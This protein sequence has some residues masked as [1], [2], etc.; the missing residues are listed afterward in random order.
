MERIHLPYA[1][2]ELPRGVILD[3][4][5]PPLVMG[6]VNCNTDSFFPPS[7]ALADKAVER[8]LV[9]V[10]EGAEII[11][12]GAESTRP[13]AAYISSGE[14]LERLI[15]VIEAIRRRSSVPLS[16][17]TR[18]AAVAEACHDAG[19][20]MINDISALEDD[21]D[22]GRVCGEKKAAV[23]L[24]H[25]KGT[26][27]DMQRDPRYGDPAAEVGA[28]LEAAADRAVRQGVLRDR[29]ILDPGIGFGKKLEDNLGILARLAEICRK[30][31]PVLVG[32]SRKTFVGDLTGRPAADRL[33]GTLAAEAWSVL[34]GA[35]IIRVHDV[36]ETADL[37][38][39]LWG[40]WAAAETRQNIKG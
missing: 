1:G 22:M 17:D 40:I 12:L 28:Y 29:I 6:I 38:R 36:R 15:P 9:L 2:M 3:L 35:R 16:V 18:K 8:A 33:A 31:Y 21:P 30:G 20:D 32:L 7:R 14:E 26:P 11:D 37:V 5:G 19:A 10:D 23:I 34:Q 39:V 4:S 24:M 13:G 27:A 25:K